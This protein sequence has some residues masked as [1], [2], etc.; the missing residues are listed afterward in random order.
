MRACPERNDALQKEHDPEVMLMVK[1]VGFNESM[2]VRVQQACVC[3]CGGAGPCHD[4]PETSQC[5]TGSD[6]GDLM[7]S[8]RDVKT[9]L[10]C[11]DRGTCMC[12]ACVCDQSNLGTIYGTFCEKDDFSCPN[13]RGLMCGGVYA[14]VCVCVLC[15]YVYVKSV[16]YGE[17]LC[18]KGS[19]NSF[20]IAADTG[21]NKP[22][23]V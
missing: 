21:K 8:C 16:K 18:I 14:N 17:S 10:M 4:N 15:V 12:G 5:A 22:S 19:R 1:P 20:I 3:S 7:N 13:E 9:G 2:T 23:K 6:P 11:S